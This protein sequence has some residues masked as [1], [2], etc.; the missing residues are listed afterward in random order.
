[1]GGKICKTEQFCQNQNGW[2]V[3]VSPDTKMF[4]EYWKRL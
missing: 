2:Q 3:C 4:L 1:M